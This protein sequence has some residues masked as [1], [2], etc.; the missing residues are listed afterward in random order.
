MKLKKQ[1]TFKFKIKDLSDA[2]II[3][4]WDILQRHVESKVYFEECVKNVW[5][6]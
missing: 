4:R 6:K 3:L 1:I 5:Y 2:Q